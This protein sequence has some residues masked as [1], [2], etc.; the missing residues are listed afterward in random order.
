MTTTAWKV[1]RWG[2]F[3][4][5]YFPVFGLNKLRVWTFFVRCI[6]LTCACRELCSRCDCVGEWISC[7]PFC[8][9]V[10]IGS[11]KMS[12]GPEYFF[13]HSFSRDRIAQAFGFCS[14]P[15]WGRDC[16]CVSLFLGGV[17]DVGGGGIAFGSFRAVGGGLVGCVQ[18]RRVCASPSEVYPAGKPQWHLTCGFDFKHSLW[19]PLVT[20]FAVLKGLSVIPSVIRRKG[21]FQ[22]GCFKKTNHAKFSEKQTFFIPWYAHEHDLR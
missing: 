9:C 17:R 10:C 2:I 21:K 8:S 14:T 20:A 22:N 15:V 19:L 16:G 11:G 5:Q 4:G 12:L 7:L 3:S 18:T 13:C 1:S 6:C